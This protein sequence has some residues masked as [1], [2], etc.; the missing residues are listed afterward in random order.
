EVTRDLRSDIGAGSAGVLEGFGRLRTQLFVRRGARARVTANSA[1]AQAAAS[2]LASL[3]ARLP[4]ASAVA[5]D[6]PRRSLIQSRLEQRYGHIPRPVHV[7][8]VRPGGRW[9]TFV[10]I[11]RAP[12][13]ASRSG[14]E[15]LDSLAAD[16]FVGLGPQGFNRTSR[17]GL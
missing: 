14:D 4:V 2:A 9:G 17:A 8:F 3:L 6:L 7:G 1:N 5:S 15:A 12:S 13:Y 10:M 16:A 11:A